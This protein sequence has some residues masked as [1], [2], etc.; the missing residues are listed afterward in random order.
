M[1]RWDYWTVQFYFLLFSSLFH[2]SFHKGVAQDYIETESL[3]ISFISFR[4]INMFFKN[5]IEFCHFAERCGPYKWTVLYLKY[6]G[7]FKNLQKPVQMNKKRL[8][9]LELCNWFLSRLAQTNRQGKN[10]CISIFAHFTFRSF[11][12]KQQHFNILSLH[13]FYSYTTKNI[14]HLD[15]EGKLSFL[16]IS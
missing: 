11:G 14:S 7:E 6:N 2:S 1:P 5:K 16:M 12:V 9:E 4:G 10:T 8:Y 13:H 15:T 3:F